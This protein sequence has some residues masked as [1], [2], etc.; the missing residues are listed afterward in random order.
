MHHLDR[1]GEGTGH[2]E[3]T[4]VNHLMVEL[5]IPVSCGRT[6]EFRNWSSVLYFII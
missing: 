5:L 4:V 2:K 6:N 3:P 1:Y